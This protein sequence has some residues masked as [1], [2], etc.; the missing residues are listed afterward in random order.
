MKNKEKCNFNEIRFSSTDTFSGHTFQVLCKNKI[1]YERTYLAD[2]G[3]KKLID[4]F[5]WLEQEYKPPII[6]EKEKEYLSAVIKPFRKRIKYIK[7]INHSS[8]N[9]DQFLCIVLAGDRC[10]LPNFKKGTMY[11]GMEVDKDYT[12]EELGL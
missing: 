1:I 6:D 3:Q 2:T 7:K 4:F 8:V 11:K 12:L 5:N 10:G 9:N